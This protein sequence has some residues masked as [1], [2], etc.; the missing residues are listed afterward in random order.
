MEILALALILGLIP[1]MIAKSKGYSFF[2]WYIYGVLLFIVALVHAVLKKP[3]VAVVEAEAITHGGM[4][5]CPFCAELIREEASVC[6]FCGKEQVVD[7]GKMCPKCHQYGVYV[8]TYNNLFC[9]N[10]Q[11]KASN[12]QYL[13]E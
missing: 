6:R 13:N 7:Q 9:P 3:N 2:A 11:K 12:G 4:K 5:K 10:C 8:D 1:A